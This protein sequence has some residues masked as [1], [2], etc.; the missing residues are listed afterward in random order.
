M[1]RFIHESPLSIFFPSTGLTGVWT[2]MPDGQDSKIA[3][4]GIKLR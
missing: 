3:A 1:K 4:I 2:V